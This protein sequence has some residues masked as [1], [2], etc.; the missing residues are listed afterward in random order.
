MHCLLK[1]ETENPAVFNMTSR[2]Q[3][4]C[5]PVPT[6]LFLHLPVLPRE[7]VYCN[8]RHSHGPSHFTCYELHRNLWTMLWGVYKHMLT[9]SEKNNKNPELKNKQKNNCHPPYNGRGFKGG[10]GSQHSVKLA[11]SML[12]PSLRDLPFLIC[13]CILLTTWL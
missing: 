5:T 3:F 11:T 13:L 6:H 4:N 9:L 12:N 1:T 2:P 8:V 7:S 10:W